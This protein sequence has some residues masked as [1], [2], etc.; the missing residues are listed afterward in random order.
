VNTTEL[1]GNFNFEANTIYKCQEIEET[2]EDEELV[3]HVI[4]RL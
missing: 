4:L 3:L 1:K 2:R